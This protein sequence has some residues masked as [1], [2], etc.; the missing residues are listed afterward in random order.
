M[1]SVLAVAVMP[2]LLVLHT[3]EY[4]RLTTATSAAS[5]GDILWR[6]RQES[7]LQA[8]ILSRRQIS[9]LLHY[10]YATTA[11]LHPNL[12]RW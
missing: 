3:K 7:N 2:C 1:G 9:N 11:Y 8:G 10:R 6:S 5:D 12:V 4:P